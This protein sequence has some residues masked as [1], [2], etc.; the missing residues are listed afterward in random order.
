MGCG[1]VNNFLTLLKEL[2]YTQK[3]KTAIKK[4][5]NTT[6]RKSPNHKTIH[7]KYH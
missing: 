4:V 5:I 3:L 7:N 6:N 1:Y 2:Y